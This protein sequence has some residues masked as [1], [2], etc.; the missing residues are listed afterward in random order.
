MRV[1]GVEGPGG[2]VATYHGQSISEEGN[3]RYVDAHFAFPAHVVDRWPRGSNVLALVE[4]IDEPGVSHR[5]KI[6]AP[7]EILRS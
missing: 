7:T 5:L 3:A 6:P 4:L 1:T 2:V